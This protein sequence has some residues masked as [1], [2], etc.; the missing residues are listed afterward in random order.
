MNEKRFPAVIVMAF[1]DLDL[2]LQHLTGAPPELYEIRFTLGALVS[3]GPDL[4]SYTK[5]ISANDVPITYPEQSLE[6]FEFC[7]FN[8]VIAP[9][10]DE[11]V[12]VTGRNAA[13]I[14][15]HILRLDVMISSCDWAIAPAI[16][17]PLSFMVD[18]PPWHQTTEWDLTKQWG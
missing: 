2:R 3:L 13:M 18:N 1:R 4:P 11:A 17:R 15:T 16:T 10:T 8:W 12:G 14:V 9:G 5:M 7:A 6:D